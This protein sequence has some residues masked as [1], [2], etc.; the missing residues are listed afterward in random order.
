MYHEIKASCNSIRSIWRQFWAQSLQLLSQ[1]LRSISRSGTQNSNLQPKE[2]I[3]ACALFALVAVII[4][5]VHSLNMVESDFKHMNNAT[6]KGTST[7]AE[8]INYGR[9]NPTRDGGS[10]AGW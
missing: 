1:D 8:A 5:C 9:T 3:R 6:L 2:M 10:W 7:Y 4:C